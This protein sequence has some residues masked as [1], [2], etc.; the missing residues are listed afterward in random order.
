MRQCD[1]LPA[2][3][4]WQYASMSHNLS[5][6]GRTVV[7]PASVLPANA[8]A[9]ACLRMLR[10]LPSGSPLFFIGGQ[11]PHSSDSQ[12]WELASRFSAHQQ[13]IQSCSPATPQHASACF[14][15]L[16]TARGCERDEGP[17]RLSVAMPGRL[18][19]IFFMK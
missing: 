16:Q 14:A 3:L 5:H 6:H 11:R 2:F 1:K 18:L 19:P 15:V 13:T 9:E 12:G 17:S 4:F 10:G 8:Q 7:I